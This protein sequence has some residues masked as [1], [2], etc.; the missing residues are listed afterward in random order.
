MITSLIKKNST[1]SQQIKSQIIPNNLNLISCERIQRRECC[2]IQNKNNR[3][4]KKNKMKMKMK[5]KFDLE[6]GM[7]M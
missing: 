6:M 3:K 2:K 1:K 4:R 7:G 5:M